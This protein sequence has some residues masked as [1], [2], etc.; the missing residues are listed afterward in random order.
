MNDIRTLKKPIGILALVLTTGVFPFQ[1]QA[2]PASF[3]G[4]GPH[5]VDTCSANSA[6]F[7]TYAILGV[8]ITLDGV[9]DFNVTVAGPTTVAWSNPSAHQLQTELVS[10][11]LSG[12][13]FT[14]TAGDG[15]GNLVSDGP[16]YSPGSVIEQVGNTALAD[17]FFDVF[18]QLDGTPYGPLHN[19]TA[20]RVQT[21][22]DQIVPYGADFHFGGSVPLYDQSNV[23]RVRIGP[24]DHFVVPEPGVLALFA[25][26]LGLLGFRRKSG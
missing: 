23:E 5:W 26:G 11:S 13:G 24:V 22:I 2:T 10:M 16:L 7:S 1:A 18:F 8:D 9:P 3:C 14:L 6:T 25:A 21:V 12:S 19:N 20:L 15:I 4:P 17:S